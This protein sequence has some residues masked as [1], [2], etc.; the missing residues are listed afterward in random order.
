MYPDEEL[1]FEMMYSLIDLENQAAGVNQRKDILKNINAAISKT[2]YKDE[3]DAVIFYYN[4]MIRK[5]EHGGKYNENFLDYQTTESEFELGSAIES[6]NSA[7]ETT[8][9]D[10]NTIKTIATIFKMGLLLIRIPPKIK[11]Y[12]IRSLK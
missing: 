12:P 3:E 6:A 7:V 2:F 11:F 10:I 5:K 1:A 4:Q 8:D 9:I